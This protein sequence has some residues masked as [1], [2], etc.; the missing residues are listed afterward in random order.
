MPRGAKGERRQRGEAPRHAELAVLLRVDLHD[1]VQSLNGVAPCF[2]ELCEAVVAVN[3]V[4]RPSQFGQERD[5]LFP[6]RSERQARPA[7]Q[8][9]ACRL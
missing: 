3:D 2:V 5:C 8:E 6:F 9:V 1:L 7:R 4:K